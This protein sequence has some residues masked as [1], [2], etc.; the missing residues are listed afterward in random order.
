MSI[1]TIKN[2]SEHFGF[3][4]GLVLFMIVLWLPVF[5]TPAI[6]NMCAIA[7]LMVTWWISEALPLAVTALLPL[8]LFPLLGITSGNEVASVYMN[9]TIFLFIGG[10]VLALS[11]QRWGLHTRIALRIIGWFHG[12]TR[13]MVFGF[14]LTGAVLSMW[15]SNTA[16]ATMLLPIGLAVY[17]RASDQLSASDRQS[18]LTALMLGI[19]YSCSIGGTATLIGTPPNMAMQRIFEI[20]FPSAPVISFAQ[21]LMFALPLSAVLLVSAWLVITLRYTGKNFPAL[22]QTKN[23]TNTQQQSMSYEEKMVAA[24]FTTTALCWIF[25]QDIVIGVLSIPGWSRLLEHADL[26]NDGTVAIAA[27]L[28]LFV[29]PSRN[30]TQFRKLADLDTISELPWKIVLLFGGGFALAKG[31][32]AS[33]LSEFIGQQFLSSQ[34]AGTFSLIAATSTLVIFLTEV[35][36]NTATAQMLLPL[37]ATIARAIEVNPLLLM[38]PVTLSASMAFMMPVATPPNAIVFASGNLKIRDM[39]TTGFIINLLA[40]LMISLTTYFWGMQVFAIDA[41][42]MPDWAN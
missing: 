37:V 28:L 39:V 41:S 36:S 23:L 22:S 7:L 8:V 40:I 18:L 13:L 32:T 17:A 15:I 20:S 42:V 35:T 1:K 19:A 6:Q 3:W 33:G 10:F 4:L 29:I 38:L 5:P 11:M 12:S 31:F 25:R 2:Y 34:D 26:I 21:W 9:S 14:M 30:Q 16:S 27:A 24:V